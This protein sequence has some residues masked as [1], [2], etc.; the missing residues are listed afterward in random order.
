MREFLVVESGDGMVT[1]GDFLAHRLPSL[2]PAERAGWIEH[3][4]RRLAMELARLHQFSLVHGTLSA[5]N[6]LVGA[7]RD[8]TRVQIAA[9][10][11]IVHKGRIKARDLVIE[12]A[13][14]EASVARVSQIGPAHRVRFLRACLGTRNRAKARR[15]WR[16]VKKELTETPTSARASLRVV[17]VATGPPLPPGEARQSRGALD[18]V[19]SQAGAER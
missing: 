7:E 9:V 11:H 3:I 10:E 5:A 16:G 19:P 14:L 12:L 2:S 13:P 4:S 8:D 15:I 17:P 1:L 6:V 18:R